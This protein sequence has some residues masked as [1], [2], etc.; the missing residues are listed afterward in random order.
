MRPLDRR[1]GPR[2]RTYRPGV[3]G[4]EGRDLPSVAAPLGVLP[5]SGGG[6]RPQPTTTL[7]A[8]ALVQEL[9]N[10]L[11]GPVT[12]TAP[13]KIG[14]NVFPAGTYATPQPTANE[15]RRESFVETF[16]GRYT[17]GPPRFSDQA[18]TIHIFSNGR[19]ATSNQYLQGRS[20]IILFPP[21]DP[22][23]QPTTNDPVAGQVVGLITSFPANF[24]QSS[25][26]QVMDVTNVPGVASNDP[27]ALD[28]GLPAHLAWTW[29]PAA[30]GA[31]A[32]PQ[33]QT[34]PS[35]QT[36]PVTG[37]A[38]ALNEK[39]LGP[40]ANFQGAGRVDIEYTPDPH[41]RPGT[42]GSGVVHVRIE[43]LINTTGSTY[44]LAKQIN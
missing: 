17:I 42:L 38:V 35:V 16:I 3:E 43:G 6:Q 33:F 1:E 39:S 31:Y 23:A 14:S 25:S 24:L 9:V 44:A 41:P 28:H 40:V 18:S 12:T 5:R 19:N 27:T 8:P 7:L 2:R 21:A 15:I 30:G 20:Q 32:T 34:N 36:D 26:Y 10:T 4:L 29:D 11:Y 22:A 13:I 37:A